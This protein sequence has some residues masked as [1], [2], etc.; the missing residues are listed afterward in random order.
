MLDAEETVEKA[1]SKS[2]VERRI[3]AGATQ[4]DGLEHGDRDQVLAVSGDGNGE[5]ETGAILLL[6]RVP[7]LHPD[8]PLE[9]A[10]R[11]IERWPWCRW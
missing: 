8:L 1:Y 2:M 3:F 9:T 4:S 5:R 10:L 7:Y 11:Y 6:P